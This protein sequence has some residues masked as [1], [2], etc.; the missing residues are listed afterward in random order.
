MEW[1]DGEEITSEIALEFT[2]SPVTESTMYIKEYKLQIA[3][4]RLGG[5][6]GGKTRYLQRSASELLWPKQRE[7]NCQQ[8]FR[9]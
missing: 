9:E 6:S 8:A 3:N 2:I 1:Q 5:G 4:T 7:S